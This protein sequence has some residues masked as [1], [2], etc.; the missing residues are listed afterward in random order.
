MYL[1]DLGRLNKAL[2]MVSAL[3]AG[4]SAVVGHG[5]SPPKQFR[6]VERDL[7]ALFEHCAFLREIGGMIEAPMVVQMVKD[8]EDVLRQGE[9]KDGFVYWGEYD[10]ALLWH[11]PGAVA[12]A[13]RAGLSGHISLI[14]APNKVGLF[15]QDEPI[16]GS[17]VFEKF[18]PARE[19]VEE[20]G[21]C[22]ALDR[23]TAAVFHLMRALEVAVRM[24]AE[25]LGA[26]V[27]DEHGRYLGWGLIANNMRSKIDAMTP[28]SD[29]QIRWY[30]VQQDLVAV[31][32]AWRV[33]TN[34]PKETYTPDQARE[35]F[36]STKAFMKELS[37]L[38]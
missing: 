24:I 38:V 22:L 30:R 35:V 34:H 20:A 19:D 15:V 25:K 27:Q 13:F 5:P 7:I 14:L 12:N 26:T 10:C 4:M 3:G 36:D 17:D 37:L 1:L 16:F 2:G 21:K 29:E 33:P 11:R 23:G 8:F 31:N 32:R 6:F 28:G 18:G 9:I